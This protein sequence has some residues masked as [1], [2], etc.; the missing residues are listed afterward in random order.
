MTVRIGTYPTDASI[1]SDEVP[2]VVDV[3]GTLVATDLLQEAA[4]Q[5]VARQPLQAYRML[6]WLAVGKSNLKT[7]LAERVNPGIRTV[8]LRPEVLELIRAAQAAG[9]Q[10]YLASASDSRYVEELAQ[11]IGGI[12]GI[13][14]TGGRVN[15][16]GDTKA[17]RLI[18][19]FGTRGYDYVGDTPIDFAVWRSARRPLVVAR[20]ASFA[21]RALRSFPG[22]EIVARPRPELS[23]YIDALRVHQWAKNVLVFLPMIAGHRYNPHTI[24]AT[25]LAFLCFCFAASAAYVIND[26]LDLQADRDHPRK[27]RRPFAAGK[28][29]ITHGLLLA[30]LLMATA[31][32]LSL[33]LPARFTGILSIYIVCTFSYSLLLKRKVLI[34]VVVLAGLYTLRVFGGLAAINIQQTQ[35]LLMFSLFLFLSLAIVK[36]CSELVANRATGKT[37]PPG[38]GYRVEDLGVLLPLAAAAGYGAVFV[39]AL[40]LSSPEMVAL[41][42]HPNRLWLVC[43]LLIYWISRVLIYANRGDLT[44]DP[45]TFALTDRISW[46]VG[47]GVAGVIA[48][49]I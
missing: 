3:D 4:L 2:L 24:Y 49:S 38:R 16:S 19:A 36:R 37:G 33:L 12:A 27:R 8:P 13:F 5:F 48:V 28:L 35:W 41:Y 14:G 22:A 18:A 11:R 17:E 26:L 47:A 43:P 44:D 31:Y 34:D 23:S 9:R 21:E 25:I 7:C 42:S 1:P 20:S 30:S 6:F 10:V 32:A 29:A 39:V 40:Y 46:I 15:L 45:V